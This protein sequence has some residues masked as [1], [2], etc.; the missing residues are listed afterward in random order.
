MTTLGDMLAR[1]Q[2]AGAVRP[3]VDPHDLKTLLVG[4]QAMQ[5]YNGDGEVT[6]RLLSVIR[7]GLE[8]RPR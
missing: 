3:D 1:A 7:D 8:R 5:R 4:A 6:T 2:Q